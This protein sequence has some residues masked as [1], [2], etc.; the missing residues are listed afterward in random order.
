MHVNLT[1]GMPS[2]E[3]QALGGCRE[4]GP[5]AHG[6]GGLTLGT[7]RSLEKVGAATAAPLALPAAAMF[8]AKY[9]VPSN[10]RKFNSY[11]VNVS[12]RFAGMGEHERLAEF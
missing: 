10:F 8:M 6:E 12:K 11:R 7:S 3:V 5:R 1:W 9:A 2:G 4:N